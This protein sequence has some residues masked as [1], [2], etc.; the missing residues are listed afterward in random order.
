MIKHMKKIIT[1]MAALGGLMAAVMAAAGT[2]TAAQSAPTMPLTPILKVPKRWSIR[3]TPWQK[4]T[5]TV[6]SVI[7]K[8]TV[9]AVHKRWICR[10]Y[11][12]SAMRPKIPK[13]LSMDLSV[14]VRVP[15]VTTRTNR[16]I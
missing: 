9:K 5:K 12:T 15:R 4:R 13:N 16:T 6:R 2:D 7:R 10:I 14:R 1:V 11:V 8:K 3:R